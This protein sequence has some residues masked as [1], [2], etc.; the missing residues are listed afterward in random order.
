MP[1]RSGGRGTIAGSPARGKGLVGR[2]WSERFRLRRALLTQGRGCRGLS[3]R[4]RHAFEGGRMFGLG[5]K[6]PSIDTG[7]EFA[8]AL[9]HQLRGRPGNLFFSPFSIRPAL[10]VAEAGAR[11]RT[12]EQMREVLGL[13]EEGRAALVETIRR[14]NALNEA[15][16]EVANS[17]WCQSGKPLQAHFVEFV[18]E[19][20][21]A[22]LQAV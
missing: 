15:N 22:D 12:A 7:N 9:Y 8:L 11:G 18:A 17:L 6:S 3:W 10:G 5:T 2:S 16:L 4:R 13:A 19:Q 20:Y 14:L 1:P 21:R